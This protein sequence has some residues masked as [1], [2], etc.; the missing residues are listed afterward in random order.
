MIG[1][2]WRKADFGK[3]IQ[4]KDGRLE[5]IPTGAVKGA[6]HSP[7]IDAV[8]HRD[9]DQ[10]VYANL[11]RSWKSA[12]LEVYSCA[13][14][15]LENLMVLSFSREPKNDIDFPIDQSVPE[16]VPTEDTNF[17]S[18]GSSCRSSD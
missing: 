9:G 2:G 7:R 14:G 11:P 6:S 3:F 5:E 8:V 17:P 15:P 18:G 13:R 12:D 1:M 10:E 16:N 4:I